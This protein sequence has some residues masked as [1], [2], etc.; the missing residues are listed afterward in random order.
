MK[1][2]HQVAE[3]LKNIYNTPFGGKDRGRYRFQGP[4]CVNCPSAAG[5]RTPRL[6]RL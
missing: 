2:A 5:L 4:H 3:A 1:S 6:M